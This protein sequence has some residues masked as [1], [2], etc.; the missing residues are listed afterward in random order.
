MLQHRVACDDDVSAGNDY[1]D[2]LL[3]P[4]KKVSGDSLLLLRS[5]HGKSRQRSA[6]AAIYVRRQ[7]PYSAP[8]RAQLFQLTIGELD[9][10][11]WRVSADGVNGI[12]RL[13]PQPFKTT[14]WY[15]ISSTITEMRRLFKPPHLDCPTS[16]R[17]RQFDEAIVTDHRLARALQPSPA[18]IIGSD[19]LRVSVGQKLVAGVCLF[20]F[21]V[22]DVA[23][24][25]SDLI[26]RGSRLGV[27][28][29]D[30][31]FV[32]FLSLDWLDCAGLLMSG[33]AR[34]RFSRAESRQK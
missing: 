30:L 32:H 25:E 13:L 20:A 10:A 11:V 21:R 28:T 24:F 5:K 7:P 15:A 23:G 9:D 22:A 34:D 14:S 26:G 6:L 3:A 8:P 4:F 2:N 33:C 31:A 1:P 12:G 18:R 29:A 16:G 27:I 19:E 17:L